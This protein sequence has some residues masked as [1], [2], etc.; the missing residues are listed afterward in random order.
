[1][2]QTKFSVII[3][4][5]NRAEALSLTMA[6]L[7]RQQFPEPWEVIVVN[8]RSTDNTDEIVTRHNLPVPLRLVHEDT[9]GAAAARNAGAAH[10]GGQYLLFVDNDILVESDFLQRH[11]IAL[12]AH[13]GA[14]I[15]GQIANLPEQEATALGRF[16]KSM[17]PLISPEAGIRKTSSIT[18]ANLSLSRA[19]F[20][21]LG[22]FDETLFS[23]EDR[24]LMMRAWEKG[25]TIVLDPSIV[26]VHNDWAGSSIRDYCFRNRVYSQAEPIFWR[27]YGDAYPRQQLVNE[28]L[29]PR[30]KVDPLSLI[31]WKGVKQI[32]GTR[33][34]QS[35]LI[36]VC[37]ACESV[38][39][40]PPLL[41]R[42]YRLAVAG[43]I[44]RGFQEGLAPQEPIVSSRNRLSSNATVR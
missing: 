38:C 25:I 43:A 29:P 3:P 2:T 15:V 20:E 12:E 11:L 19:D 4:T 42:F 33:A 37:K 22:G 44:Y 23:G 32:L 1:M 39:P 18:A 16:R 35:T 31:I 10:A 27:K 36:G 30:W 6:N 13:A 9:P 40:W 26:V 28:N 7:A 8:N 41:W 14:W 5:H 17:F 24:E 34:G 21:S